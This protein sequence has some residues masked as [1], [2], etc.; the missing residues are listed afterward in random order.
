MLLSLK[1]TEVQ[2][3][4]VECTMNEHTRR[5]YRDYCSSI[6]VTF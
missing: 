6:D 5:H 1:R 3:G 4:G 2:N